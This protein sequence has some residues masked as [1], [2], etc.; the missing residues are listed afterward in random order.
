[1]WGFLWRLSSRRFLVIPRESSGKNGIRTVASALVNH[2]FCAVKCDEV[3]TRVARVVNFTPSKHTP[4]QATTIFVGFA[5]L[6]INKVLQNLYV[7][8]WRIF[9]PCTQH[10]ANSTH[11]IPGWFPSLHDGDVSCFFTLVAFKH[12]LALRHRVLLVVSDVQNL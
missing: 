1:M 12:Q 2:H 8:I 6:S 4:R 5:R 10:C 11:F 3:G 9:Q 7:L